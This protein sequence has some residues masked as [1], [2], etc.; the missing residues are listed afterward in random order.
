M[1]KTEGEIQVNAKAQEATWYTGGTARDSIWL[2]HRDAKEESG[3]R[4]KAEDGS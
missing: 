2:K 3:L 4:R 1:K